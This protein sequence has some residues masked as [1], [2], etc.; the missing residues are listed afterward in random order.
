MWVLSQGCFFLSSR[1]LCMRL[2]PANISV[3][4]MNTRYINMGCTECLKNHYVMVIIHCDT[5]GCFFFWV[6]DESITF[7]VCL[8]ATKLS[9][10]HCLVLLLATHFY[11]MWSL[12]FEFQPLSGQA[13]SKKAVFRVRQH[14]VNFQPHEQELS[15]TTCI[16]INRGHAGKFLYTTLNIYSWVQNWHS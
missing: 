12:K 9:L 11:S 14:K 16:T 15:Y 3:S 2:Y 5:Q 7:I 13:L 8:R 10:W 4:T 1:W 6:Q